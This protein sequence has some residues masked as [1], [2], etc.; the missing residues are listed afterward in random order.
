MVRTVP[1]QELL[2][3][4]G[5]RTVQ[6]QSDVTIG[7]ALSAAVLLLVLHR[8][9]N[10]QHQERAINCPEVR[11]PHSARHRQPCRIKP[12]E[13]KYGLVLRAYLSDDGCEETPALKP[14]AR[15]P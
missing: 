3:L 8:E 13:S 5:D 2:I 4:A 12:E 11:H 9:E 14:V 6:M 10:E 7:H 15:H 1:I